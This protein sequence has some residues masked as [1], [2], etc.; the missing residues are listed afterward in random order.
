MITLL[1]NLATF[2]PLSI[3]RRLSTYRILKRNFNLLKLGQEVVFDNKICLYESIINKIGRDN[4]LTYIEFGVFK[5]ESIK[6]FVKNFTN[7]RNKFFGFDSFKGL[8]EDWNS[9]MKKK[10]FNL[11]GRMPII[12]DKRCFFLKGLFQNSLP[13]FISKFKI[14]KNFQLLIH[15]DADIYSSTLY[16]LVHTY[17]FKKKYFVIFDQF[18]GDE[19]RAFNDFLTSHNKKFKIFGFTRYKNYPGQVFGEVF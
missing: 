8:P 14:K 11:N 2:I 3:L 17:N 12:D 18:T 4:K 15:F 6:Y 16:S 9:G 19:C 7:K 13:K 1:K 10:H 5:G